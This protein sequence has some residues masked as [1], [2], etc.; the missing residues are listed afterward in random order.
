VQAGTLAQLPARL[1]VWA[2]EYNLFD[3]VAPVHTTWAQGL[4][5]GGYT[6]DLL[7]DPRVEQADVH[8][9]VSSAPFGALFADPNGLAFG[10]R[11][12]R[13]FRAPVAHPP[14]TRPLDLSATGVAAEALLEALDGAIRAEPLRFTVVAPAR[15]AGAS[16]A[17]LRGALLQSSSGRPRAIILNQSPFGLMVRPPAALAGARFDE[18]WAGPATLVSGMRALRRVRGVVAAG[19][20][21]VPGYSVTVL[22]A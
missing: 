21:V 18:R 11:A 19:G 5:L 20:V 13:G 10:D 9:L 15:A 7:T 2:T 4:A 22:S 8:A 12:R 1:A 14:A 3:R 17:A 6:L 16:A